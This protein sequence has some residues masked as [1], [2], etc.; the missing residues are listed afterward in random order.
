MT[1][2]SCSRD[3]EPIL[4]T[5]HGYAELERT[6][7][8]AHGLRD[9]ADDGPLLRFGTE[10]VTKAWLKLPMGQTFDFC[11]PAFVAGSGTQRSWRLL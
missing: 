11:E 3:Y 8:G 1:S 6:L 2:T 9:T 10:R 4:M 7:V 5:F